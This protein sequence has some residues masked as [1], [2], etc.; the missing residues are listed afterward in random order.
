MACKLHTLRK[1]NTN[2]FVLFR[3]FSLAKKE[4][5]KSQKGI[6]TSKEEIP[7]TFPYFLGACFYPFEIVLCFYV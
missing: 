6:P 1:R 2:L 7:R 3:R 5:A 4:K